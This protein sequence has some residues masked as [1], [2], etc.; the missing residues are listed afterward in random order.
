MAKINKT[1]VRNDGFMRPSFET[2]YRHNER[3]NE[4][5]H[6][7]DIYPEREHLNV[8]YRQNLKPDGTR[9]TYGETFDRLMTEGRISDKWLKPDSKL[10]DEMVFDVNTD[11]F[12]QRGGYEYAKNFFAAA[13]KLAVKE[14]GYE[15]Y[16]LSAVLHADERN[17]ALSEELGRDVYHYHLHVVYVPVVEKTEYY[18]RRKNEPDDAPRKVKAVYQ[19]ISHAKKWPMRVQVERDGK[20]I[21]LNSY[22]LLQDRFFDGIKAAGFDDFE[23]GD[24]KSTREHLSVVEY[25]VR[26]EKKRL[27]K[28][29]RETAKAEAKLAKTERTLEKKTS[30]SKQLDEKIA[31]KKTQAAT[32][33]DI[34]AIGKPIPLVGGYTVA[35]NEMKKLKSWSRQVFKAQ[36][37]M[38][39]LNRDMDALQTDLDKTKMQLRDVSAE[40]DH[41]HREYTSLWNEVKPFIEAIRKFPQKMLEFV[42]SLFPQV[43]SREKEHEIAQPQHKKSHDIGG[44]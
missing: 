32:L 8:H 4:T 18:R 26:Q 3:Q 11:C 25:K 1:V 20:T 17:K 44:R 21:T 36:E 34:D 27:E 14:V 5:Y 19:Q 42:K 10:I 16:I 40:R 41:W 24:F 12:E 9:E 7:G 39:K 38:A 2:R 15:D 29:E 13:Y 22:S 37:Q 43:H 30:Q 33:A 6:N 23:R 28:A 35:E 31:V